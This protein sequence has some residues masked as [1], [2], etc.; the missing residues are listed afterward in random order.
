[1][2]APKALFDSAYPPGIWSKFSVIRSKSDKSPGAV[3]PPQES[4]RVFTEPVKIA[5]TD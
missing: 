2:V 5:F 1:M 4:R 3:T